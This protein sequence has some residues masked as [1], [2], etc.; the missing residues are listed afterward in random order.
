MNNIKNILFLAVNL[1]L[2]LG[3]ATYIFYT[4]LETPKNFNDLTDKETTYLVDRSVPAGSDFWTGSE[5]IAKLYRIDDDKVPIKVDNRTFENE[6]DVK[7]FQNKV[8]A[9]AQYDFNVS[10]NQDGNLSEIVFKK[11]SS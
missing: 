9:A 10:Y 1:F 7:K 3:I 11:I 4:F 6:K 2:F 5:V 8:A